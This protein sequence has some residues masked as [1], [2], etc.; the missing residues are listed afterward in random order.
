MD[1]LPP[2]EL[3]F[4]VRAKEAGDFHSFDRIIANSLVELMSQ[5]LLVIA[6][7]A[8]KEIRHAASRVGNVTDDDIPF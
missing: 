3:V 1:P 4:T 2:F 6:S 8:Q 5:F 7:Y